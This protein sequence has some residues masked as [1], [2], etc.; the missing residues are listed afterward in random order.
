MN[1]VNIRLFE[2]KVSE[3][4][5]A[6]VDDI[7]VGVRIYADRDMIDLVLRNLIGN[8]IKFSDTDDTIKISAHAKGEWIQVDVTDTGRGMSEKVMKNVF[9]LAVTSTS[10]TRNEKGPGL[11]LKLCKDFVE[12]NGGTISVTSVPGKGSTFSFTLRGSS[13]T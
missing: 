8:A 11:G 10:G 7:P 5:I 2:K 3:K 9:G 12:K 13:R 1:K 4:G 6:L